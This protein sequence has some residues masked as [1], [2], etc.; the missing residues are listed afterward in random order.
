MKGWLMAQ[1]KMIASLAIPQ[2]AIIEERRTL[3]AFL[4]FLLELVLIALR[5]GQYAACTI[6]F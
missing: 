3:V 1:I 5:L 6:F 2:R 4:L